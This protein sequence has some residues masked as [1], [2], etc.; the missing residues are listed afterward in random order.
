MEDT[1]INSAL[2]SWLNLPD[3]IEKSIE[4]LSEP[5]LDLRGGHHG[6]S[7]R[8]TTHH[9]VEANLIASTIILA[10]LAPGK[11]TTYDWSWVWPNV[12]WMQR[13]GYSKTPVAPALKTLRAL[14]EYY[15]FLIAGIPDG[16]TREVQ[17]LDS[18][19]AQLYSKTVEAILDQ[20]CKHVQEH[21]RD[22]SEIREANHK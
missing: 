13:M 3:L 8:E 4:G 19:G 2:Q 9:L 11:L 7:I 17:L 15:A 10:A 14:S 12:E 1:V 5:D 6:A 20:E 22:V 16:L 21:L 18:P